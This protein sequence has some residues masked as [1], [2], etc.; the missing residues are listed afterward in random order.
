[1]EAG[2]GARR[3]TAGCQSS[4]TV[5]VGPERQTMYELFEP[6]DAIT[7]IS[8]AFADGE[9][10]PGVVHRQMREPGHP[11][12]GRVTLMTGDHIESN[13][14]PEAITKLS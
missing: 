2:I 14:R 7:Y 6:G 10:I 4:N 5:G 8:Y 13:V 1:M 11:A 12:D 3:L 9:S